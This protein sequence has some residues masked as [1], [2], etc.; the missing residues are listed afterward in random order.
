MSRPD[1]AVT[2][3]ALGDPLR[4]KLIAALGPEGR[5]IT[6]L[7][8]EVPITRQGVT[9]HLKVLEAG[10][11]VV[12]ERRG[13]E[14]TWRCNASGLQAARLALDEIGAGWETSL[15]RLK[16]MIEGRRS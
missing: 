7:A 5:S 2:F 11:L 10:A 1:P 13:R 16:A 9:K 3:A 4:L 15:R 14:T 8:R 6:D 12:M